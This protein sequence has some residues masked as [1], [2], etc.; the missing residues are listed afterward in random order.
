M[1]VDGTS[2]KHETT[3]KLKSLMLG[4]SADKSAELCA[5]LKKTKLNSASPTL[6]VLCVMRQFPK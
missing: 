1:N 5:L 2:F 4:L 6:N 3:K